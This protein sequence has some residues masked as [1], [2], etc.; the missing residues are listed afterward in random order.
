MAVHT[1]Y[2]VRH[3]HYLRD[4]SSDSEIGLSDMGRAQ[5]TMTAMALRHVKPHR[6][7]A[8]STR[9]TRETAES[10]AKEHRLPIETTDDLKERVPVIPAHLTDYFAQQLP[11]FTPDVVAADR[12]IADRAFATFFAPTDIDWIDILVSHGNLIQYFICRVLDAP[13]DNWL[14]LDTHHASISKVQI[15]TKGIKL[16]SVNE[17][18]HIAPHMQTIVNE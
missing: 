14:R 2:V 17:T 11:Q 8:S 15:S 13:V 16:V 12:I 10:I 4:A 7:I 1:L 5:A 9:R 6:I 3:A 18:G